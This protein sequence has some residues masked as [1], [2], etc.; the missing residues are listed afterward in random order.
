MRKGCAGIL[1]TPPA[2]PG[3]ERPAQFT[4]PCHRAAGR[5]LPAQGRGA[6]AAR[7]PPQLSFLRPRTA[8]TSAS[9]HTARPFASFHCQKAD[10]FT[11][12]PDPGTRPAVRLP[13]PACCCVRKVSRAARPPAL[14]AG[15]GLAKRSPNAAAQTRLLWAPLAPR[16]A[17]ARAR[18]SEEGIAARDNGTE[19]WHPQPPPR[20]A[21]GLS[22]PL[23]PLPPAI[24]SSP[25]SFRSFLAHRAPL[26]RQPAARAPRSPRPRAAI[27]TS[28]Y[29]QLG[30]VASLCLRPRGKQPLH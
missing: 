2:Q 22:S 10:K 17:Q 16:A 21:L 18:H 12:P 14:A 30:R 27:N 25:P 6:E 24:S 23:P 15:N 13:P 9:A 19:T 11:A 4:A 8:T 7:F 26:A 1:M 5:H 28:P 3:P 29:L 20:P